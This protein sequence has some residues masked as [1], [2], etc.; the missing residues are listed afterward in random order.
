MRITTHGGSRLPAEVV[1]E[2]LTFPDGQPH[3]AVWE[4]QPHLDGRAVSVQ[5]RIRNP[6]ELVELLLVNEV[7]RN[8]G[9]SEVWLRILY[10]MG[11][12]MDRAIPGGP[13]TLATVARV[14]R[15]AKWDAMAI[16][17]PHSDVSPALLEAKAQRPVAEVHSAV[18]AVAGKSTVI[19]SPDAGATKRLEELALT[20]HRVVQCV[21]HR[22]M[23]TGKLSGF[24][25]FEP[26]AVRG[27]HCLIVDDL[28]DGGGTFVGIG[29]LLAGA[30]A[31]S[32]SLYVTHGI[33][34]RGYDLAHIG[35][36]FTTNSY[37]TDDVPAHVTRF[38]LLAK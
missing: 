14:L 35:R 37:R 25:L 4:S 30:G 29:E 38:D 1:L 28:C 15:T 17:D 12:R 36:I 20:G 3:V 27:E 18:D 5:A 24:Q 16:V 9:A 21:K 2:K 7:L 6:T 23:A 26:E 8:H 31:A 19:V 33:F 11:A 22:D 13:F 32:V 34:S 10:L